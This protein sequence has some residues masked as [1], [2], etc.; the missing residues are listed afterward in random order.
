MPERGNLKRDETAS[1]N[2]ARQILRDVA[3]RQIKIS[4]LRRFVPPCFVPGCHTYGFK[5]A[6]SLR[7][8]Q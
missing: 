6:T 1:R 3:L 5:I 8:S 2:E 4:G 7:S